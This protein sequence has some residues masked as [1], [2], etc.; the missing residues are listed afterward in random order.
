MHVK[1]VLNAASPSWILEAPESQNP[2]AD[3]NRGIKPHKGALIV[4]VPEERA[5]IYTSVYI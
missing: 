5:Q 2:P 1:G 3:G 4:F